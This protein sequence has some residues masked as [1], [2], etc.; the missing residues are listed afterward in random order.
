MLNV[1]TKFIPVLIGPNGTISKLFG[2]YLNSVPGRYDIKEVHKSVILGTAL[3]K[4][5]M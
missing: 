1:K 2:G 4:V 5:L 3:N